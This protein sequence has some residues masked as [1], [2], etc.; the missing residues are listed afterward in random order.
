MNNYKAM[1]VE[2]CTHYALSMH[3]LCIHYALSMHSLYTH[4]TLSIHSLYTHYT[5]SLEV[6]ELIGVEHTPDDRRDGG[7]SYLVM[8]VNRYGKHVS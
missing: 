4:Y 2:V 1:A 7:E 3:S 5:L 8:C 6:R